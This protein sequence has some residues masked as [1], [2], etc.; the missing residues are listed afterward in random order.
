MKHSLILC[1]QLQMIMKIC[2]PGWEDKGSL[3]HHINRKFM[4][5][6]YQDSKI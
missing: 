1:D 2:E 4:V 3:E 6:A 5:N